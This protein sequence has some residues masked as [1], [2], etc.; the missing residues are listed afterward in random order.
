[1]E[2]SVSQS[3][4]AS[5]SSRSAR[6]R[7]APSQ[8]L[9]AESQAAAVAET[10][11]ALLQ[12][13]VVRLGL[14]PP[15]FVYHYPLDLTPTAGRQWACVVVATASYLESNALRCAGEVASRISDSMELQQELEAWASKAKGGKA[16][17]LSKSFSWLEG[18]RA[19]WDTPD[20]LAE[21][22]QDT[23]KLK[24]SVGETISRQLANLSANED[25]EAIWRG[26]GHVFRKIWI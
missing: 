4:G 20:K 25:L 14:E 12:H 2:S 21:L 26:S 17:G 6:R 24:D 19:K 10:D 7:K 22:L 9:N 16:G 3:A 5:S 1:M 13:L 15:A 23:E 18:I 8:Q 11:A